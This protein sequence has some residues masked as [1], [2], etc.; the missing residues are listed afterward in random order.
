M[1]VT[2]VSTINGHGRILQE[3]G[4]ALSLLLSEL[5][6][7][8][9]LF[10]VTWKKSGEEQ[11]E[12]S[13]K[14]SILECYD[15]NHSTSIFN[16]FKEIM[17]LKSDVT[18]YNYIPTAFGR[19][20]VVNFLGLLIPLFHSFLLSDDK[21][22]LIYHSST[23]TNDPRRLGYAKFLERAAVKVL[24]MVEHMLFK[25]VDVFFL[26]DL[27]AKKV[28]MVNRKF[29]ANSLGL[30]FLPIL[31]TYHLSKYRMESSFEKNDKKSFARILLFGNFGPQKNL[32]KALES[33]KAIKESHYDSYV[34]LA[35]DLNPN[36]LEHSG[37]FEKLIGDY[38]S[39]IDRRIKYVPENELLGLFLDHNIV[40][41]PYNV[42]G[43][44]SGVLSLCLILNR[45][46]VVP[47]F[48]EYVEQAKGF[49]NV[50]FAEIKNLRE[51][52]LGAIKKAEGT[53]G[54]STPDITE[55][56]QQMKCRMDDILNDTI[57]R[58]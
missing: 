31:P 18:I 38:S 43:G 53:D 1:R 29:R 3:I 34:T 9:E 55:Y 47:P 21:V 11:V 25:R 54:L 51:G 46:V 13:S 56:L 6:R 16:I 48:E 45:I 12:F 33:L 8:E 35:G 2:L 32:P 20:L 30:R 52:I 40:V 57:S 23:Y 5:D 36:F 28:H 27:Y 15:Q 39:I 17:R 37:A 49:E 7:V 14:V 26:L 24:R 50:V 10:L 41:L 22:V 19:S 44:F 58:N 42:S 4:T